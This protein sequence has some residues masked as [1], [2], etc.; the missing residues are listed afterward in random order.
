MGPAKTE[1]GPE[2]PAASE[3]HQ[4]PQSEIRTWFSG[5]LKNRAAKDDK[6]KQVSIKS[7]DGPEDHWRNQLK[8][9]EKIII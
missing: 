6:G 4:W 1:F 9:K 2:N 8:K 5:C 7:G 3:P